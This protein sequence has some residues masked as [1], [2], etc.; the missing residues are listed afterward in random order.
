MF[1][2]LALYNYAEITA[3]MTSI[4]CFRWLLKTPFVF[5]IPYMLMT[6]AAELLGRDA[7]HNHL[8]ELNNQIFNVSTVIEFLFFYYLFYQTID[9]PKVKNTIV[10]LAVV[11]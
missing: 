1:T 9:R 10:A 8:F 4:V 11:Y 7:G 5:F 2:N 3:L 6:V